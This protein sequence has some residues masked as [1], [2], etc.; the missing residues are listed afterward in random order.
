MIASGSP[1]SFHISAKISFAADPL[2]F[3][4][5]MRR[6]ST[7]SC[8]DPTREA[9]L[10]TPADGDLSRPRPDLAPGTPL[11]PEAVGLVRHGPAQRLITVQV[12]DLALGRPLRLAVLLEADRDVHVEAA[13][14]LLEAHL[15]HAREDQDVAKRADIGLALFRRAHVGFAHDLEQRD[16]RAVEVDEGV[17]AARVFAGFQR[18][19][20]PFA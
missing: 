13:G 12:L 10:G 2:T 15:G 16:P 17:A 18:A 3:P 7:A 5:P 20:V 1:P 19:G 14:A 4:L 9:P 8:S 6:T 11:L